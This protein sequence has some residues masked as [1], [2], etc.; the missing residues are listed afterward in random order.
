LCLFVVLFVHIAVAHR[1]APR[2][3]ALRVGLA[4]TRLGYDANRFLADKALSEFSWN[5]CAATNVA[6]TAFACGHRAS[7]TQ[8]PVVPAKVYAV[9]LTAYSL[10]ASE[11]DKE[12]NFLSSDLIDELAVASGTAQQLAAHLSATTLAAR[13]HIRRGVGLRIQYGL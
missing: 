10:V 12:R 3:H 8:P 9:G 2:A 1:S 7:H 11:A 6:L 4:R 5:K 13:S